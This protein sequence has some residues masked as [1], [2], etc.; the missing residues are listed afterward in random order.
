[1]FR[2]I[3]DNWGILVGVALFF[4][5]GGISALYKKY[6]R[7][8]A[9]K[10]AVLRYLRS[11]AYSVLGGDFNGLE[12]LALNEFAKCVNIIKY[13]V[14]DKIIYTGGWSPS[15]FGRHCMRLYAQWNKL[16]ELMDLYRSLRSEAEEGF[17]PIDLP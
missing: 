14:R 16:P 9:F 10:R 11:E 8:A 12:Q 15:E 5:I 17:L 3:T 2:E 6:S 13:P 4:A 1:M 7:W